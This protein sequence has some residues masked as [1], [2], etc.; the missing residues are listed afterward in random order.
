MPHDETRIRREV[1]A[2]HVAPE[3]EHGTAS[4][5]VAEDYLEM[6]IGRGACDTIDVSGSIRKSYEGPR[7][8]SGVI[9]LAQIAAGDRSSLIG[10]VGAVYGLGARRSYSIPAVTPACPFCLG[11]QT[12]TLTK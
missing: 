6:K 1:K 2:S 7:I 11:R 12:R 4:L 3:R 8:L 10:E 9:R 5:A